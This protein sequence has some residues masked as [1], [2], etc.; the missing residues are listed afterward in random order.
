MASEALT[1]DSFIR[2]FQRMEHS[3]G[4]NRSIGLFKNS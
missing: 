4:R 2:R 1:P 3:E